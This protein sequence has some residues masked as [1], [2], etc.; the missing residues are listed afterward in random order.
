MIRAAAIALSLPAA[1]WAQTLDSVYT[2]YD[3]AEDCEVVD[4]DQ[5]VDEAGMGGQL[6]CPGPDGMYLMLREG[7]ARISMDYGSVPS[8]GPWESF[9]SFNSV[10]DTVEWRRQPLNGAMRPFAT[11]HRWRV[12]PS[13]NDRD[14]L[15]VSTV[16]ASAGDESCMVGF[17]DTTNTPDANELARA[18]ADRYAP[19]FVCGN[20]VAR[21]VGYVGIETPV[22]RRVTPHSDR[23]IGDQP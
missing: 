22:P 14:L 19:G 1:A 13:N 8:F 6:I 20:A 18:V 16:A 15:I 4:K 2:S 9:S 5:P 21:G 12:G 11:I 17:I 7:D 23:P 10:H 3:W